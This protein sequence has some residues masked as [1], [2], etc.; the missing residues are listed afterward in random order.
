[1]EFASR[2]ASAA[3]NSNAVSF[4]HRQWFRSLTF[5]IHNLNEAE[6]RSIAVQLILL[7]IILG[8]FSKLNFVDILYS[9]SVSE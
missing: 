1:V 5:Q 7:L 4:H 2:T 3:T 6:S 9:S 8:E